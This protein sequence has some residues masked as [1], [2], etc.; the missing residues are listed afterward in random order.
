MFEYDVDGSTTPGIGGVVTIDWK[1]I[2]RQSSSNTGH[3][4]FV[5]GTFSSR[6][7]GSQTSDRATTTG[8]FFGAPV[9]KDIAFIGSNKTSQIIIN[10]D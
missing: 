5:S 1:V 9:P 3:S 7:S 6:F 8:T 4:S 10:R 2:P